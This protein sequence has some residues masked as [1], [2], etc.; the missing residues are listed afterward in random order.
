M[1]KSFRQQD[2][3]M[4]QP[5]GFLIMSK[6]FDGILHWLVG[7]FRLTEEEQMDAG[8]YLGNQYSR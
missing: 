6:I 3:H 1:D 4:Q 7:F 2:T 8:I 5:K